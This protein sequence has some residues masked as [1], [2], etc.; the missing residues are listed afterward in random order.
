VTRWNPARKEEGDPVLAATMRRFGVKAP[1]EKIAFV[2]WLATA[3][4]RERLKPSELMVVLE[5]GHYQVTSRKGRAPCT[6]CHEMILN[7]QDYEAF[8]NRDGRE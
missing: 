4:N 3:C 8:R 6:A 2:D 1:V 5:C 7:G